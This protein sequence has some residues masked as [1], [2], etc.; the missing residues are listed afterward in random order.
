MAS[1]K[2]DRARPAKNLKAKINEEF[3]EAYQEKA[4][5]AFKIG[6][7]DYH[8]HQSPFR[9]AKDYEELVPYFPRR[10]SRWIGISCLVNCPLSYDL[11]RI[12]HYVEQ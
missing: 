10:D 11:Q 9:E 2:D 5:L 6:D 1:P 3:I 7:N 8:C 4:F 12:M